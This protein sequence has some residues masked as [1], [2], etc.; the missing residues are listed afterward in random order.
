L[1]LGGKT[2]KNVDGTIDFRDVSFAYP[3]R[4]DSA[5]FKNLNL[6][7][8]AGSAV[9]VVGESGSGKR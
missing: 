6:K 9:A 7:V 8:D 4:S 1:F 5:V 2:L 3:S